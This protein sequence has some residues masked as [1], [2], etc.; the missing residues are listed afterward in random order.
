MNENS[1]YPNHT[2][3]NDFGNFYLLQIVGF[4]K[5]KKTKILVKILHAQDK[6]SEVGYLLKIFTRPK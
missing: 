4:L 5:N 2:E 1:T 3:F 6:I